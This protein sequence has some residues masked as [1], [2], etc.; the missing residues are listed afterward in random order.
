M[1]HRMA[2]G[3]QRHEVRS[4][5]D[6]VVRPQLG[7]GGGVVYLDQTSCCGTITKPHV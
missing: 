5:V 1:C 3:A 4:R 6:D 7:D 2:V